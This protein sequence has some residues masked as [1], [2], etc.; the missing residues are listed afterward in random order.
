MRSRTWDKVTI[1][2]DFSV[3][4]IGSSVHIDG[5]FD[6]EL[7]NPY[8]FDTKKEEQTHGLFK[9][10]ATSMPYTMTGQ[11][12][13]EMKLDI[14]NRKNTPPKADA[15]V[16]FLSTEMQKLVEGQ[17]P[18]L[19]CR[20]R[21]QPPQRECWTETEFLLSFVL[22]NGEQFCDTSIKIGRAV[23]AGLGIHD[24]TGILLAG[25]RIKRETFVMIDEAW[26]TFAHWLRINHRLPIYGPEDF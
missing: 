17:R 20:P 24:D 18:T 5:H 25:F 15:I 13:G 14:K 12:S 19:Q 21:I 9:M 2:W 11:R 23:F 8:V 7:Y 1:A 16:G 10:E 4:G 3:C 22:G 6:P 26:I